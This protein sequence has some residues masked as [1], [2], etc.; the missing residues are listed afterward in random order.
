MNQILKNQV[1]LQR[2]KSRSELQLCTRQKNSNC[3]NKN[4]NLKYFNVF[5]NNILIELP[6]TKPTRQSNLFS[7]DQSIKFK[8]IYR[9]KLKHNNQY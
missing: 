6:K 8:N 2:E 9:S 1:K 7:K 4:K 5:V 3:H